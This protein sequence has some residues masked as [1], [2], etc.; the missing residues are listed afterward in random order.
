MKDIIF[1]AAIVPPVFLLICLIGFYFPGLLFAGM[2]AAI[3]AIL[4]ISLVDDMIQDRKHAKQ[5]KAIN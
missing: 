4:L 3:P 2:L 5:L 1:I